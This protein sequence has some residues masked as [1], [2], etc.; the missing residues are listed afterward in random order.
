[1]IGLAPGEVKLGEVP[2]DA[3]A[4]EGPRCLTRG[5]VHGIGGRERASGATA[6]TNGPADSSFRS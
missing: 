3:R 6:H 5:A 2:E 1:M 4:T